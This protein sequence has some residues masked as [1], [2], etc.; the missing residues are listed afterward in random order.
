MKPWLSQEYDQLF[1]QIHQQE[2]RVISFTGASPQCG[3]S[4]MC[5]WL[6]RR[7]AEDNNK[8]LLIDLDLSGLGQG[9]HTADWETN[10]SGE[11]DAIIHKTTQLDILPSPKNQETTMALRQP[12]TLLNTIQRWQQT[13]HYIIFDAGTI[14]AANWRNLPAANICHASDAAILCIAAAKTTE[15]EV[16]TSIDRLKQGGVNLLGCIVNDQHNPSLAYEILRILDTKAS[17]LP[18]KIKIG[19]THYLNQ[20]SMLQGKY[21]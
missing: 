16:L 15:S 14:S 18:K 5:Y 12:Q 1:Q 3:S 21:Q 19:L 4:T 2:A 13:Y 20:N 17:W 8:V 7:C 6:A 9:N 10:G 11:I